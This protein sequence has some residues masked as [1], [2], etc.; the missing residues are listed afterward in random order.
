M[1]DIF[2]QKFAPNLKLI[3]I[4]FLS[5]YSSS[6]TQFVKDKYNALIIKITRKMII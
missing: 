4:F 3:F 2:L 1:I 6:G 5:F